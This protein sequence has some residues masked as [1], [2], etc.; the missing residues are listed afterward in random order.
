MSV[1]AEITGWDLAVLD[2]NG[3]HLGPAR[4]LF[5][6]VLLKGNEANKGIWKQ[7]KDKKLHCQLTEEQ[8]AISRR[9]L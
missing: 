1:P 7:D 9:P 5:L 8:L 4:N 3:N 2:L 6:Q